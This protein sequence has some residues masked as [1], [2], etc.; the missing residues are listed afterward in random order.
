MRNLFKRIACF[1]VS[2]AAAVTAMAVP[3]S[4]AYE[5]KSIPDN[6]AT[7]FVDSMG[8]GWN[9]GNAFDSVD[10][11][12][13]SDKLDYEKG[14]CGVKTTKEL[15]KTVKASG[16]KTIRVPVSWREHVDASFNIDI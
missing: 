11:T 13:L 10:C 7:R 5:R 8:A 14:W 9:L 1:I 15:I 12:W 2:A 4:A 3:A 16:F 6:D